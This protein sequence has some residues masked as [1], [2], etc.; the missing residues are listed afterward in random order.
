MAQGTWAINDVVFTE[1]FSGN[2]GVGGRDG[3]FNG[4]GG[5]NPAFDNSNWVGTAGTN[6]VFMACECVKIGSSSA[7]GSCTTPTI[8]LKSG[9]TSALLT[10]SAAGWDDN[11]TNS[12]TVN[13]ST[14]TSSGDTSIAFSKDDNGEWRDYSVV[15]TNITQGFTIEFTGKRIFLD[16]VVV[17]NLEIVEAPSLPESGNF[18]P[19]TTEAATKN[20]TIVPASYSS[21]RYT[22]D[23]STPT[24]EN[25]TLINATSSIIIDANTTIKAIGFIG[26][27]ES[28]VVTKTY[29][30]GTTFVNSIAEFNS[31]AENTEA[32]LYLSTDKNTRVLHGA[33]GK[34]YLRDNTGTLCV[35]LGSA[36]AF[37]PAPAHNQHIAGW[38]IG[39]K[40]SVNGLSKLANTTNT[41]TN[42]LALAAPVTEAA[43]APVLNIATD[44]INNYVGNWVTIKDVRNDGSSTTVSGIYNNAL[45]D[46]S[47]IVTAN[48]AILPVNYANIKPV[49]YVIDEEKD[50][51]SPNTNITGA[52]VRLKRTLK[53]GQWNTFC[54]P[55]N[56]AISADMAG[57]Y[58]Q[59]SGV[60]NNTMTFS[61]A[62]S[63][64]AG[65]PYLVKPDADIVNKTFEN[66]TLSATSA[67][68]ITQGTSTLAF[69]GTYSP[70][71]LKTDKTEQFLTASG[72]LAYPKTSANATIKGMRAY[73]YVPDGVTARIFIDGE[74]TGVNE[75]RGKMADGRSDIYNLNGQKVLNP[76]KGLYIVNGKKMVIK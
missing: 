52:T 58:R 25:G 49:V 22:T 29:T 51:A 5:N 43:T 40:Q 55:M 1:T 46:V 73:F 21:V 50:F 28:S 74:T 70:K 63:I 3:T 65:K 47:G 62:N 61:E 20:I 54:V 75:V 34:M 27:L 26:S 72:Q 31:L 41:N 36:A 69:I 11:S 32:Q 59:Y 23:G 6:K 67:A 64:E 66:V 14:G 13:I 9:V 24:I 2:S 45:V 56:L 71:E 44:D 68:E 76:T 15:I 17:R 4:T 8:N 12:L 60:D 39:K 35:D 37:N 42:H 16:D 18:W 7:N 53:A 19:N 30:L 38:I 10:F 48:N 33:D 57:K